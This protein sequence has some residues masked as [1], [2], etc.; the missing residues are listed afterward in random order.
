M[1]AVLASTCMVSLMLA[2]TSSTQLTVID[3]LPQPPALLT[4]SLRHL[5]NPVA[6]C[7]VSRIYGSARE[8][9]GSATHNRK[10]T[11]DVSRASRDDSDPDQMCNVA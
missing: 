4:K 9:F 3:S 11:Y 1:L 10:M 2:A 7:R 5:A 6:Y 8:S